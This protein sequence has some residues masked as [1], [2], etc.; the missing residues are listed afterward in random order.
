MHTTQRIMYVKCNMLRVT[1]SPDAEEND[2]VLDRGP[3]VRH[4]QRPVPDHGDKHHR[5]EADRAPHLVIIIN[6]CSVL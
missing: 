2:P 1:N 3:A 4:G 6:K 5:G